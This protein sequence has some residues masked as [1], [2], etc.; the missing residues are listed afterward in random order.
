MISA[1]IDKSINKIIIHSDDL[2]VKSLLEFKREVTKYQ[3]W[4]KSWN[5]VTQIDKLY[6]NTRSRP[7]DGVYTFV[8][9]LGWSAYIINV[10]KSIL[11]KDDYDNILRSIYSDSYPSIPFPGLRDYQN[12]DMLFILKYSRAIVQTNTSYGKFCCLS[13]R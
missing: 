5:T 9:G 7:K 12:E 13:D 11:S 4:T 6:E 8:L 3:P 1:K 2:S 10:F